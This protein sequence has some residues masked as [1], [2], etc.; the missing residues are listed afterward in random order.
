MR[1]GV[2]ALFGAS[3]ASGILEGGSPVV[4][5]ND[6]GNLEAG[7]WI[8]ARDGLGPNGPVHPWPTSKGSPDYTGFVEEAP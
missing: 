5:I 1:I 2:A 6:A 4:G 7:G 8:F 3:C